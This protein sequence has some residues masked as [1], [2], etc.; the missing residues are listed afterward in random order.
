VY[1][2]IGA[3]VFAFLPALWYA[4]V[5]FR[6]EPT[7]V[8]TVVQITDTELVLQ[9]RNRHTLSLL[10]VPGVTPP[11]TDT[12]IGETIAVR[13]DPK[14]DERREIVSYEVID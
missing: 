8:G 2:I 3:L 9:I 1:F 14:R 12:L 10:I 6:H 4:P 5:F 13:L 11:I 7:I